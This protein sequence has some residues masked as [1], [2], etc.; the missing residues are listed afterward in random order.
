MGLKLFLTFVA[1][2][3]IILRVI[4]QCLWIVCII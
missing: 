2:D 1:V 3:Y 4:F